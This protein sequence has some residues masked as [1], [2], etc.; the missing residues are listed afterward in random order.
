MSD[1]SSSNNSNNTSEENYEEIM[2]FYEENVKQIVAVIFNDKKITEIYNS[3][4][5]CFDFEDKNS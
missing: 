1:I 4:D 5:F 3:Q 2:E